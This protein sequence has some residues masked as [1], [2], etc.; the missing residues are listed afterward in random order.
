LTYT[1]GSLSGGTTY[2]YRVRTTSSAGDSDPSNVASATTLLVTFPT[3]P[4][5]LAAAKLSKNKI[6]LT[7]SDNSNNETG[8]RLL[9]SLDGRTW[10]QL[11]TLPANTVTYTDVVTR[12]VR[13]YYCVA[14]FNSAGSSGYTA[15]ASAVAGP[16]APG[17][18]VFSKKPLA[19]SG[20]LK[21][22][23]A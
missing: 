8:F 12:G 15:A 18:S 23:L 16:A 14:A 4:S 6:K 1:N 9:E 17:A 3:P 21:E 7:W 10:K 19:A 22:L 13:Y 20:A 11:A 5:G 2:H